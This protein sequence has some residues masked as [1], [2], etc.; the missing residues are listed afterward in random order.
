MSKNIPVCTSLQVLFRNTSASRSY[1][2]MNNPHPN[3]DRNTPSA[4]TTTNNAL[5]QVFQFDGDLQDLAGNRRTPVESIIDI[6]D[7]ALRL[8]DSDND[9][10]DDDADMDGEW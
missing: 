1:S 2:N 4:N 8:I 7:E 10:D 6:L 5:A 3:C 9:D